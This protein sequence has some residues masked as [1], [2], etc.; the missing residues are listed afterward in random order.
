M[1]MTTVSPINFTSTAPV[2]QKTRAVS[3]NIP[4]ANAVPLTTRPV[5]GNDKKKA[6]RHP[7]KRANG[8]YKPTSAQA[9]S[10]SAVQEALINLTLGGRNG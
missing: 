4:T 7:T 6:A 3:R 1:S 5:D 8:A 9:M 10:S 2:V